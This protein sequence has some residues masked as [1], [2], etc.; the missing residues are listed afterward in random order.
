MLLPP[1]S[2]IELVVVAKAEQDADPAETFRE[3]VQGGFSD[4]LR[5]DLY[6]PPFDDHVERARTNIRVED[7]TDF[8][9]YRP[10]LLARDRAAEGI[11]A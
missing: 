3:C 2:A 6:G 11:E 8:E 1:Q 7:V 4:F 9:L 10:A 5:Q